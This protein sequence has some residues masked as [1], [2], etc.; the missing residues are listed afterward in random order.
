MNL[1]KKDHKM[2]EKSLKI[3]YFELLRIG[4]DSRKLGIGWIIKTLFNLGETVQ[5]KHLP[6]FYDDQ[7]K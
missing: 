4:M 1:N 5:E 6:T 7:A 2:Y 3:F